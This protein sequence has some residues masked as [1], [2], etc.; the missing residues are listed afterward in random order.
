MNFPIDVLRARLLARYKEAV[1]AGLLAWAG[2][3]GR[4]RDANSMPKLPG[5]ALLLQAGGFSPPHGVGG[6]TRQIAVIE[7]TAYAAG[8]DM[9]ARGSSGAGGARGADYALQ[10]AMEIASGF[11]MKAQE[12][13][14]GFPIWID[15]FELAGFDQPT[16]KFVYEVALRHE[17]N[18]VEE[19]FDD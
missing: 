13:D 4:E 3:I 9:K 14:V 10:M 1:S 7:W 16:G 5:V 15:R 18:F 17:W 2:V 6:P 8:Q 12:T 11:E 19:G